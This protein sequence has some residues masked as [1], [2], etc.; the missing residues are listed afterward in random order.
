VQLAADS[1]EAGPNVAVYEIVECLAGRFG[2]FNRE[3]LALDGGCALTQVEVR[4]EVFQIALEE[5]E[6]AARLF[7]CA[8]QGAE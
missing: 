3:G 7:R 8:G 5:V 4:V 2:L 1:S 6:G